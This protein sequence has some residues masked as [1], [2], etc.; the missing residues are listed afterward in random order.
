MSTFPDL[1]TLNEVRTRL[2]RGRAAVLVGAGYSRLAVTSDPALQP[3]PLWG[4]L[5][6]SLA[7][8]LYPADTGQSVG[9]PMRLA[10]EFERTLGRDALHDRV[11]A[12]VADGSRLPSDLHVSL[13]RLPWADVLTTNYDTLLERAA[14]Q[15]GRRYAPVYEPGDLP[16]R[17]APRVVKLHGSLPSHK[18]LVLTEE[19]YRTYPARRAAFV[20]LART[21]LMERALVLVGFSGD[22]P[23]FIAWSG[24]V[25]DAL[26]RDAP[27]VYLLGVLDLLPPKR[28]LLQSRSV[29]PV[30]LGPL[31][32]PDQWGGTYSGKRHEAAARWLLAA[33]ADAEPPAPTAWPEPR[34][35]V[36]LPDG[37]PDLPARPRGVPAPRPPAPPAAPATVAGALEKRSVD[38]N[39]VSDLVA[40]WA[41]ERG[42]YP[43]WIIA[44]AE[45]RERIYNAGRFDR[46]PSLVDVGAAKLKGRLELHY[47][48]EA[49]W[50]RERTLQPLW[51]REV[52]VS[53]QILARHCPF[54][55]GAPLPVLNDA[56]DQSAGEDPVN[57]DGDGVVVAPLTDVERASVE[58]AWTES[59]L[60]VIRT[61]R[62][63]DCVA[64]FEAWS[65]A[66]EPFVRPRADWRAR[67]ALEKARFH[68][69]QLDFEAAKQR[70]SL[71]E[72]PDGADAHPYGE[73]QRAAVL[74]EVGLLGDALALARRAHSAILTAQA[75]GDSPSVALR[76]REAYTKRALRVLYDSTERSWELERPELPSGWSDAFVVD[77]LD[78]Y[79][80]F[81]GAERELAKPLMTPKTTVPLF[82]PNRE[83]RT[84][85]FGGGAEAIRSAYEVVRGAEE[86]AIPLRSGNLNVYPVFRA[87]VDR[88]R[89]AAPSLSFSLLFRSGDKE[90][91]S[92]VLSRRRV[93]GLSE[94]HTGRLVD[95]LVGAV[96]RDATEA[97]VQ[98][99]P[100]ALYSVE[101]NRLSVLTKALAHLAVRLQ[102]DRL[103]GVFDLTLRLAREPAFQ[104]RHFRDW[105]DELFES[106]V[107]A[108]PP[109]VLAARIDALL[110][111]WLDASQPQDVF[112]R[113]DPVTRLSAEV[114]S[115]ANPSSGVIDR[116]LALVRHRPGGDVEGPDTF[117]WDRSVVRLQTLDE[118]G[119]LSADAASELAAALWADAG[120][121]VPQPRGFNDW[122]VLSFPPPPGEDD[123]VERL[124]RHVLA[125]PFDPM[126]A[127]TSYPNT[128]THVLEMLRFS[129]RY[130]RP[131]QSTEARTRPAI[132]WTAEEAD[133]WIERID[134]WWTAV[135]PKASEDDEHEFAFGGLRDDAETAALVLAEGLIPPSSG[136]V[137]RV[138]PL[139]VR[140]RSEGDA[141]TS[142]AW[143]ALI[144]K[145][146]DPGTVAQEIRRDLGSSSKP[147]VRVGAEAVRDWAVLSRAT[148]GPALPPDLISEVV[149]ILVTRRQPGLS[150]AA[151]V[152]AEMLSDDPS[153]LP[154]V[155][156]GRVHGALELLLAESAPLDDG[157]AWT[158]PDVPET[159]H[160][161]S[162]GRR[163]AVGL[164]AALAA[165]G[166]GS[167]DDVLDAWAEV[168]RTDPLPEVRRA[169][170]RAS[171]G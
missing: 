58:E 1:T 114:L 99:W 48:R 102:G 157:E 135:G 80:L 53:L 31:F 60:A 3:A 36:A 140:L 96:S 76:S 66:A 166:D 98:R 2:H 141:H 92:A 84:I 87:A 100:S 39:T 120:E 35:R 169:A 118:A 14:V 5:G 154:E 34:A 71:T 67:L 113:R 97:A 93:A 168:G 17:P 50:R 16:L 20:A 124:K 61:L 62:E 68:I 149:S 138:A 133:A 51:G 44:P 47:L 152:L 69:G 63:D 163:A 38:E 89:P 125:L 64:E 49:L 106:L 52:R 37:L 101:H 45:V 156:R 11:A 127:A 82:R 46:D 128:V 27:P 70:V 117:T 147:G 145:G 107:E 26:G 30:D 7:R 143:V 111:L 77:G 85:S 9:D 164:A 56:E 144:P 134:A 170:R 115:L 95:Q 40:Q 103:D 123:R 159:L 79:A 137:T 108:G 94:D 54:E 32:P 171:G 155:E 78:P 148:G 55:P 110:S 28:A 75:Q 150:E 21:L 13:L 57:D 162:E 72:W 65:R 151:D 112:N 15:S 81:V 19:D 153:A 43:G 25:R 119:K 83:S 104:G 160:S 29:A 139:L 10:E 42:R 4:E 90:A 161:P 6:Q 121:G 142:L 88:I 105:T 18:P 132:D 91:V 24:W 86:A 23:N 158:A 167:P 165:P 41:S 136:G 12:L 109:E 130:S 129:S 8:E 33:L 116:L 22:D 131:T 126:T 73:V 59:V 74:A 122:A 146:A